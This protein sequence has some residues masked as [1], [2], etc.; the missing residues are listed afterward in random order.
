M[1]RKSSLIRKGHFIGTKI[2]NIRKRNNLTME[3]LSVRCIQIDAESAPS[4][5]YLSMIE[6]GKRVPSEKMLEVIADVFQKDLSWFLDESPD[7]EAIIDSNPKGGIDG[8]ALEPGF[9]FSKDHLQSALP[10]MLSQTGTSGQQFGHL[11]IRAHQE[12]HHNN[13]P[14]LEKAAE[15]VGKKVMPLSENDIYQIVKKMGMTIK[16]FSRA[17]DE[18][19]DE[20]NIS[21]KTMVRSFYESPN[22]IYVNELLKKYPHSLKYD[23]ATHIGH[24]ALYGNEGLSSTNMTGHGLMG[25]TYKEVN[26]LHQSMTID[27]TE[28]LQAWRDFECSFFAGALLCPK[29]P[30]KQHLN[31]TAYAINN[32]EA[33]GV[34]PSTYMRRMTA[35][36]PYQHW[37]YFDTYQPAR[38]KAVYRGNGIPLPIGNMRPIQD[39]CPHWSLFRAFDTLSADPRAQIS[40]LRKGEQDVIYSCDSIRTTDLAGN[41]HVLCVGIDLN[42]ALQSQ[43]I[44]SQEIAAEIKRDCLANGGQAPVAPHIKKELTRIARVLNISWVERGLQ[45]D[46][47]VICSRGGLCPRQEKC[48]ETPESLQP[49]LT[50]K[51]IRREIIGQ[52]R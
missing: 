50:M 34:S 28:I 18:I 42:P 2:R 8:V 19:V 46:A 22:T 21:S 16:W 40:I 41:P 31:R 6:N 10:E 24:Q 7:K 44:D 26:E 25:K 37:H 51:D 45:S 17:P 11:L 12:H 3:D 47:I 32:N 4:I 48:N 29:V 39:P 52:S 27:S 30:F 33:I 43:G 14:D 36:S 13:F 35:V 9:L 23:L 20:A 5:S 49:S 1:K 38:L 15:E